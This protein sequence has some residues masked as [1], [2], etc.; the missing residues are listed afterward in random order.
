MFR[1]AG[2]TAAV[3]ALFAFGCGKD[4]HRLAPVSGKV[5]K[6]GAP[7]ANASVVF[8]PETKPGAMPSPTSRG[9]TDKD[10]KYT[11]M[12]SEDKPGAVVGAHKVRISTLRS[13]EG[14]ETEGGAVLMRETIPEEY[15]A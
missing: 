14:S 6:G 13:K 10:G 3:L 9:E 2:L 11:L 8:L 12:T 4:P 5:T 7:L 15:N 1:C